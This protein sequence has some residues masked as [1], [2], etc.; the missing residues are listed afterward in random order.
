MNQLEGALDLINKSL[1]KIVDN[2]NLLLKGQILYRLNRKEECIEMLSL[3]DYEQASPEMLNF[4]GLVK[5]YECDF[6]IYIFL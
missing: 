4:I 1:T 6:K 3:I 5:Q 2:K